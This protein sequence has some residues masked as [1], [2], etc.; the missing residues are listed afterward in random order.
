MA[1]NKLNSLVNETIVIG[2]SNSDFIAANKANIKCYGIHT[3]YYLN[4][5]FENVTLIDKFNDIAL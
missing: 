1:I 5:T 4:N 2:D 3:N